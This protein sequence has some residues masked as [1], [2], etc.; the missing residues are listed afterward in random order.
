MIEK[1]KHVP[2]LI[3]YL[4]LLMIAYTIAPIVSMIISVSVTTYFYL[5]VQ[6]VAILFVLARNRGTNLEKYV[7]FLIPFIIWKIYMY[8]VG[9]D[10]LIAWIYSIVT[11]FAVVLCGAYVANERKKSAAVF[12]WA[13]LIFMVLTAITSIIFLI[14]DPLAAR[15]LAT[16]ADTDD[17]KFIEYTWKNIG[18]Y[19][20]TYLF[21]LFYPIIILATKK[22]RLNPWIA[23]ALTVLLIVYI[24]YSEYTTALLLFL[25]TSVFWFFRRDLRAWHIVL[26]FVIALI[27]LIFFEEIFGS[28]LKW[29][30]DVIDS[31][32]ISSRL[33]A[34]S[35][36]IEGIEGFED[37]R[38]ALYM[39]SLNTFLDSPLLGSVISGGSNGGHSFI[40]DFLASYGLVG[41]AI[42]FAIYWVVYTRLF[43]HFRNR[44][45]YGYVIWT[46]IQV[47]FLSFVN[48]GIWLTI[49][50]FIAP[51]CFRYIFEGEKDESSLDS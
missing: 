22:K 38:W 7:T 46:F 12:F 4:F 11:D 14:D 51:I 41:A 2:D 8:F 9:M 27:S 13:I 20:F 37:N 44:I 17:E 36:G 45:G 16:V 30:A 25:I 49:I 3:D 40:L 34:L 24:F 35:G 31:K 18:G 23:A 26:L 47:L 6:I 21:V 48:T 28:L 43:Y 29:L 33:R 50:G 5:G 15:Y 19:N 42:L 10:T 39:T 1:K 32:E